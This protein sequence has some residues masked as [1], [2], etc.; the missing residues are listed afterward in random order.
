MLYRSFKGLAMII[1][2]IVSLGSIIAAVTSVVPTLLGLFLKRNTSVMH[3]M[4]HKK[5]LDSKLELLIEAT[6]DS[7]DK[8]KLSREDFQ[9]MLKD[10]QKQVDEIGKETLHNVATKKANGT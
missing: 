6:E 2:E 4:S 5:E 9:A 10:I 8:S 7:G 1:E 3:L